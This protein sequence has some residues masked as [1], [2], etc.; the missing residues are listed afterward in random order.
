MKYLIVLML[1]LSACKGSSGND[2][3]QGSPG[4]PGSAGP[5][6]ATGANGAT[7]NVVTF[8]PGTTSFPTTF[9]EVGLCINNQIY[10]VYSANNGFLALLPPGTYNS[11]AVGSNCDFTI[12]ANCVVQ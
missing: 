3:A 10:G 8:C 12:A 6:G 9:L 7:I 11:N 1:M 2:G 5:Q 4:N